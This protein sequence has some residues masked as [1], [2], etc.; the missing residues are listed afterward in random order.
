MT[1]DID[2][3]QSF[4]VL[5]EKDGTVNRFGYG[6]MNEPDQTFYIGNTDQS[7]FEQLLSMVRPT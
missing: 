2:Y 7:L 6:H 4:V 5:L 1:I 3:V